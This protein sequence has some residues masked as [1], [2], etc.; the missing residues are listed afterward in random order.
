MPNQLFVF[1]TLLLISILAITIGCG[2][3]ES[4]VVPERPHQPFVFRS[5]LDEQP[6]IIPLALLDAVWQGRVENDRFNALVAAA[7]I[8]WR[9][10]VV[11]RALAKFLKQAALPFRSIWYL[12]ASKYSWKLPPARIKCSLA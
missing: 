7:G 11:M 6:R 10:S 2:K 8:T 4:S 9:E 5:V 12:L 1:R 3:K